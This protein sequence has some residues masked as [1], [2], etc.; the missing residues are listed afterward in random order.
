MDAI[1]HQCM[2]YEGSPARHLPGL[3]AVMVE[4]LRSNR[5]CLYLNSPS[6]IAGI[7]S[8]LAAAGLNVAQAV[9]KGALVL[10]SD[11]SHLIDGRFDVD[12]M[13][14]T[15]AEAIDQA[16]NDGYA[17]LWAA[18]DMTW[19]FGAERNFAKLREYEQGLEALFRQRPQL[20]GICQYH[21][22]T[23]PTDVLEE[24]LYSHRTSYINTHTF[25]DESLLRQPGSSTR[26]DPVPHG[27]Q[28]KHMLASTID[29]NGTL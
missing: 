9:S 20:Q 5:R 10:L 29:S 6:M 19:E 23:L 4:K 3:A 14:G 2:I 15:L 27:G 7:R 8:Y 21:A 22:D 28:L 16:L 18:G 1:R 12:R 17:G 11:G 26:P 25:A 24:A 13:L